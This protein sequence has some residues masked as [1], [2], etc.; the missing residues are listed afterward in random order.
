MTRWFIA[1][2]MVAGLLVV[3]VSPHPTD[4]RIRPINPSVCNSKF[5]VFWK[6]AHPIG[7]LLANMDSDTC[8]TSPL[9]VI[10]GNSYIIR[11]FLIKFM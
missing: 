10:M 7:I 8:P 9:D 1:A 5:M 3:K 4:M 2:T 11:T 6:T